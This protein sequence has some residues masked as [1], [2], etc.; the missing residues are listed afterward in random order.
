MRKVERRACLRAGGR[1]GECA[2]EATDASESSG[3]KAA[4]TETKAG[5]SVW[6]DGG[7][8]LERAEIV[9][10]AAPRFSCRQQSGNGQQPEASSASCT[11][12]PASMGG[13]QGARS[14]IPRPDRTA[15]T[16]TSA[17]ASITSTLTLGE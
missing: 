1:G 3:G 10:G 12:E 14:G 7:G 2:R 8:M 11:P 4:G 6:I 17:D 9:A 15:T 16:S 5:G 13:Q